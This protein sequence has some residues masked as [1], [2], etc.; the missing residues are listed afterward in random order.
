M[1]GEG[2]CLRG[3]KTKVKGV[4]CACG[5]SFSNGE[6]GGVLMSIGSLLVRW[7]GGGL[8]EPFR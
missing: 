1:G 8:L 5:V 6:A 2:V 3:S 7:T 4:C